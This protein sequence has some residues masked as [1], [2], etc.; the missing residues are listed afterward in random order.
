MRI[1]RSAWLHPG[2]WLWIFLFAIPFVFWWYGGGGTLPQ[3]IVILPGS[4]LTANELHLVV[5]GLPPTRLWLSGALKATGGMNLFQSSGT[6]QEVIDY[7]L[8]DGGVPIV[9][10]PWVGRVFDQPEA[11]FLLGGPFAMEILP[12]EDAS[13]AIWDGLLAERIRTGGPPVWGVASDDAHDESSMGRRF[14]VAKCAG[15]DEQSVLEALR[16]GRFYASTGPLLRDLG[17]EGGRVVILLEQPGKL[18]FVGLGGKVLARGMGT[19]AEY[20]PQGDEG[21][22]RVEVEFPGP[23]WVF[24]Q[25]FFVDGP[26][27]VSNP[28]TGEGVWLRGNLHSHSDRSDGELSRREMV[29]W[30]AA[31]GFGFVSVTDHMGWVWTGAKRSS[32]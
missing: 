26:G 28:Y 27:C 31:H 19:R 24:T 22:V 18:R 7:V 15:P 5:V 23:A 3:E 29:E 9:A 2:S 20:L 1:I 10:H 8:H 30:Y 25:P 21:Y 14:V 17:L 4:E 12:G 6:V 16:A 11:L 13:L 32:L